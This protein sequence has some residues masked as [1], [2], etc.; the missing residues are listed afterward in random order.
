GIVPA[1]AVPAG[2][3][4]TV[5]ALAETGAGPATALDRASGPAA[6]PQAGTVDAVQ[7]SN[8]APSRKQEAEAFFA[9]ETEKQ[10]AQLPALTAPLGMDEAALAGTCTDELAALT[11]PPAGG[12]P[13]ARGMMLR[14]CRA[15]A[16]A[17]A[18]SFAMY[19][20]DRS[21]A[22]AGDADAESRLLMHLALGHD[23]QLGAAK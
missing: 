12:A 8:A 17:K 7:G 5:V 2:G 1:H 22:D 19:W 6:D 16:Y 23:R 15:W 14:I 9:A 3:G 4:G 10:A 18:N 13:A 21:L 20:F 11:A